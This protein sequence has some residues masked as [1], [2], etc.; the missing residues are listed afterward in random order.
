MGG[1]WGMAGSLAWGLRPLAHLVSKL[2]DGQ[3]LGALGDL[4]RKCSL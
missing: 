4:D 3:A 1:E 2:G